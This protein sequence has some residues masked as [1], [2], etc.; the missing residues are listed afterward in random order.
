MLTRRETDLLRGVAN[1]KT[2]AEI[3]REEFVAVGTVKWHL[4]NARGKLDAKTT[5]HAVFLAAELGLLRTTPRAENLEPY[6][7]VLA[8]LRVLY[9]DV[10]SYGGDFGSLVSRAIARE[11]NGK[12]AA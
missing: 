8:I 11:R 12:V 5:A 10:E 9:V 6:A 2:A 7:A 3:A 4:K 1:G